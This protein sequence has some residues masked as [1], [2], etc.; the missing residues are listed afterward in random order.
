MKKTILGHSHHTPTI[1]K[2]TYAVGTA[3][4]AHDLHYNTAAAMWQQGHCVIYP[5]GKKMA[6]GFNKLKSKSDLYFE[7]YGGEI[8]ENFPPPR[9][10]EAIEHT[11]R[12]LGL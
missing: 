12:K 3:M 6:P 4:T 8:A 7:M 5:N 9:R 10:R 2:G 1:A 11:R